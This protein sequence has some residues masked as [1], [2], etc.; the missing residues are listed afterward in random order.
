MEKTISVTYSDCV[1]VALGIQLAMSMRHIV[2]CLALQY[3]STLSHKRHDFQGEVGGG[4]LQNIRLCFD[5]LNGFCLKHFSF[6]D[7]MGEM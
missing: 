6:H 2:A 1:F 4:E 5:F 7:E 3:F